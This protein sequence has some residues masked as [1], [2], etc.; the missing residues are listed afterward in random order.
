M[1][2]GI[3][4]G[5]PFLTELAESME[6][7]SVGTIAK[8]N[9]CFQKGR[10]QIYKRAKQFTTAAAICSSRR[11]CATIFLLVLLALPWTARSV[12]LSA[13]PLTAITNISF[14]GNNITVDSF[15]S[16][17]PYHSSWQTNW[18]YK[19]STN[20]YGFYPTNPAAL[21]SPSAPDYS[22]EPYFRKDNAFVVSDGS[23]LVGNA[24]ICGYVDTGSNQIA[25]FGPN[26]TV[27]D[28][29]WIGNNPLN[30]SN[31]GVQPGHLAND[32]NV[33]FPNVSLPNNTWVIVTKLGGGVSFP[34]VTNSSGTSY[35]FNYVITNGYG[36][37][38]VNFEI[39]AQVAN[40]IYVK[41]TNIVL[42][43]PAGLNFSGTGNTIWLETNSD[44]TIYCGANF[45]ASGN[46]NNG[47]NN[48]PRY[49]PSFAFFGLPGCTIIKLGGSPTTTAYIYAPEANLTL[50]GG[51]G[52]TFYDVIGT[53]F[54]ELCCNDR[55]HEFT[56]RRGFG[57]SQASAT[58][59]ERA[60][61]EPSRSSR[62]KRDVQRFDQRRFG[63]YAFELPLVFQSNEP[64]HQRNKFVVVADE[65]SIDERGKLFRHR[66]EFIQFSHQQ[67]G[68]FDCL[69]QRH[70]D[71]ER[72]F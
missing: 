37:G 68:E 5:L 15:D 55:Q 49:A 43:L 6:S 22:T 13:G 4:S 10:M 69:Y 67:R 30:P 72:G 25:S 8:G 47:I 9:P 70:R 7:V 66:D 24:S 35:S 65:C 61:N 33:A 29:L 18:T 26:S 52:G 45:D 21:T 44:L 42:Y 23:I 56:F 62:F 63:F 12:L 3:K 54:C 48:I 57:L 14:Q 34:S 36:G 64:A 32:M 38:T 51:G 60:A 17:D 39:T 2:H 27:G 58:H 46:G 41:G 20:H 28:N 31:F 40:P 71:S 11:L 53:F 50:N 16:R 1:K 59:G 19:N